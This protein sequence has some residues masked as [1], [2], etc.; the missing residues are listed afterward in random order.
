MPIKVW[1]CGNH[2]S[3]L[4]CTLQVLLPLL[5]FS[6]SLW[7]CERLRCF[8]FACRHSWSQYG[9]KPARP[10]KLPCVH[11]IVGA[12]RHDG[13]L[14]KSVPTQLQQCPSAK[15]TLVH[16][17]SYRVSGQIL[18][19]C[20]SNLEA[21]Q[22]LSVNLKILCISIASASFLIGNGSSVPRRRM[23]LSPKC[24][25]RKQLLC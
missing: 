1:P 5:F 14:H 13:R 9:D 19:F 15:K 12:P 8:F 17:N 16:I 24:S 25:A 3:V 21:H 10:W 18:I 4:R 2:N 20:F 23:L 11:E 7:T 22:N 6:T